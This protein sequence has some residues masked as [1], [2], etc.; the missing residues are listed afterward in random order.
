M[1]K[2]CPG[3]H[4]KF[5]APRSDR[6]YCSAACR[7]A[8]KKELFMAARTEEAKRLGITVEE[9]SRQ[10]KNGTRKAPEQP[11]SHNTKEVSWKRNIRK[12]K[13]YKQIQMENRRRRIQSGW[14]GQPVYGGG[15]TINSDYLV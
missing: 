8:H 1:T 14:R 11:I 6:K 12:P 13:T 3:C 9:L 15:H 4:H 7:I 2:V 10:I 5:N